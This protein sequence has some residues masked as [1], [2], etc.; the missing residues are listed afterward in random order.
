M[1]ETRNEIQFR[2]TTAK[3]G[4]FSC[5]I[6]KE[7]AARITRYCKSINMNRTKF[8]TDIVSKSLDELEKEQLA[9]LSK[10]QLIELLLA[11][12]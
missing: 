10:E 3:S 4:E 2:N 9:N 11:K 8:V 5:R 6:P 7:V 12:K 1:A